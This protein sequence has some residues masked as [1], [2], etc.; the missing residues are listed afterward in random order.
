MKKTLLFIPGISILILASCGDKKSDGNKS[1]KDTTATHSEAGDTATGQVN[2]LTRFK[3]DFAVANIPSPVQIINELTS[4]NITYNP[5]FLNDVERAKNYNTDFS[6]SVNL[7][8]YNVDMAY[9][10]ASNQ[11]SDVIKYLKTSLQE[12]G[13]LG[14]KNTFDEFVKRRTETNLNNR[15]SLLKIIDEIYVKSDA[16][17]R[18][19]DRIETATDIFVGSWVESFYI[20]CRTNAE[21]KDTKQKDRIHKH[22]WEQRFYLKNIIDLLGEFKTKKEEGS[23]IADLTAICTAID[24]V[25]EPKD[26]T[27]E[28]FNSIAAQITDLRNKLTK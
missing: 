16:Y 12:A 1:G 6:K 17:L 15:D 5:G 9:A 7:G 21:E 8:I 4:Y 18:S 13:A 24:A 10:G 3:F 23:L 25:K 20:I 28:T 2:D 27:E 22:L 11:G 26:L 19:N 14:I